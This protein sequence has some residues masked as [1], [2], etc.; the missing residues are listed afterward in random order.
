MKK[1]LI[2]GGSGFLGRRIADYYENKY[3]VFA[4]SHN[5]MD[6]TNRENVIEKIQ[7]ITPDC[8]IH[9][10]AISDVAFCEKEPERA[11]KINVDGSRNI[12]EAAKDIAA[13]CILCSSDQVY[14]G[15]TWNKAHDED[16]VLEPCNLYGKGK[17]AAE[18]K[19]LE[20]NPF[21][22]LLRLSWM[23]DTKSMNEQ[24]HG[25]FARTVLQKL[26]MK[27]ML[28]YPIYDRRGITY[29]RDVVQNL[30]LA[31][32]LPGGVYNFGAPNDKNTYDM[33]IEV[34]K[35]FGWDTEKI[36]RNEN[37]FLDNPR[38]M[39]MSQKKINEHGIY[40]KTTAEG[41]ME[42]LSNHFL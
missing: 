25:D 22:I 26:E 39:T 19:C 4:P 24:E 7:S 13:T 1:L 9:C 16:E 20:V 37:A 33:M 30:E 40:F 6:I 10:A 12:A 36:E 27:E 35:K 5:E 11:W 17:L 21:S 32:S 2:T 38:N 31:F 34:A 3:E 28:S 18:Q 41:L 29:V 15:S 42:Q 23:Y 8:I 14:Y